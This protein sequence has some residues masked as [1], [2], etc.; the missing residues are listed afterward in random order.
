MIDYFREISVSFDRVISIIRYC[1]CVLQNSHL[2]IKESKKQLIIISLE[3]TISLKR[4]L[5]EIC[6]AW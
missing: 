6:T 4:V 1:V 5:P 2:L 3:D